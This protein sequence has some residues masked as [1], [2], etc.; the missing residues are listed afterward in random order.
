MKQ[1]LN[2]ELYNYT[3]ALD[4]EGH[5]TGQWI[6]PPNSL[7]QSKA[8]D[9]LRN[10]SSP[11]PRKIFRRMLK[12]IWD[13]VK[14]AFP[15]GIATEVKLRVYGQWFNTEYLNHVIQPVL[16]HMRISPNTIQD[17]KTL[18]HITSSQAFKN[19]ALYYLATQITPTLSQAIENDLARIIQSIPSPEELPDI[20]VDETEFTN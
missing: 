14:V 5:P 18:T 3:A 7:L 19:N 6:L 15:A 4:S 20:N 2:D 9:Y 1:Y 11:H 16:E 17:K 12:P 13:K 8:S 10:Q